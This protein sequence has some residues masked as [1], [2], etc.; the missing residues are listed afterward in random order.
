MTEMTVPS[1]TLRFPRPPELKL[2]TTSS[3]THISIAPQQQAGTKTQQSVA[4]G[5]EDAIYTENFSYPEEKH[6]GHSNLYV[7]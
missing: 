1:S 2:E 4:E 5:T 3:N 7:N 6:E